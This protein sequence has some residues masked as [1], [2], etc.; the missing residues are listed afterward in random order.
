[1]FLHR[2]KP[3]QLPESAVTPESV[4]LNRRQFLRGAASVGIASGL[5]GAH[6]PAFGK[7]LDSHQH[8]LT[9]ESEVNSYVNFYEFGSHKGVADIAQAM[10]TSPWKVMIKGMVAEEKLLDLDDIRALM[11]L[12]ERITMHRCVEAWGFV[13]PWQGF[14][15]KA[16]IEHVQPTS[17]ARYVEFTT[18]LDEE[19]MPG[20]AQD[21]YPWPYTEGLSIEEAQNDLAFMA[22]GLYG[23]DLKPQNGAPLRLVLPWKYGFKSIKS[24]VAIRFTDQQ[25]KSFWQKI[26]GDEYGFWANVNPEIPHKRWSQASHRM[27]GTDERV[28]TEIFNGYAEW[29]SDL[30]PNY[31]SNDPSLFF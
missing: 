31:V 10:T 14:P 2:K 26:A 13:A 29:V 21:W 9:A 22:T 30:Y 19:T 18:L 15:L 1:M 16:L 24:I 27:L 7:S 23:K 28:P 8:P 17:E 20:L 11:P 4:Y 5:I 3:W 25:P 6:S 12:E